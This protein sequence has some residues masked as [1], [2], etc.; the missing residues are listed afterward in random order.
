MTVTLVGDFSFCALINRVIEELVQ[1]V[2]VGIPIAAKLPLIGS[3]VQFMNPQSYLAGHRTLFWSD[4][5]KSTH[6]NN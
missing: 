3:K 6:K 2:G 1:S 5:T 4:P